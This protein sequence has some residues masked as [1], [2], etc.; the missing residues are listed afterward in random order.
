MNSLVTQFGCHGPLV[1]W[2]QNTNESAQ[3]TTSDGISIARP[4]ISGDGTRVVASSFES[5][6]TLYAF[7]TPS[8][9]WASATQ[10]A[11]FG[12]P[13]GAPGN[14]LGY[15]SIPGSPAFALN[16]DGSVLFAGA[17]G[18][19]I[20]SNLNQGA[21]YLFLPEPGGAVSLGVGAFLLSALGSRRRLGSVAARNL[22]WDFP[23]P[24]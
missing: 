11:R 24:R 5:P 19:T 2:T 21:A 7:V 9:G 15:S 8:T 17:P 6:G 1:S 14:Q 20:G 16:T 13:D 12:A 22:K 4:R 23:H 3:L 10:G 18:A